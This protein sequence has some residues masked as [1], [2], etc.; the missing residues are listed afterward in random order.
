MKKSKLHINGKFTKIGLILFAAGFVIM[1]ATMFVNSKTSDTLEYCGEVTAKVTF[2]EDRV[3]T[4]RIRYRLS[5]NRTRSDTGR[6]THDYI[7]SFE[8]REGDMTYNVTQQIAHDV[9]G[10]YLAFEED[11]PISF[12]LYRNSDCREYLSLKEGS[13]AQEEYD[14]SGAIADITVYFLAGGMI[15]AFGGLMLC[16][17]EPKD[18]KK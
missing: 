12:R 3:H 4:E 6:T 16:M 13:A 11:S 8:V 7:V 10:E 1:A 5:P 15:L 2:L 9:Y 18:K 14:K 17:A